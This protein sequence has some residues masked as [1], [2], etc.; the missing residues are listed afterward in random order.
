MRELLLS[1]LVTLCGD[2]HA[3]V[4]AVNDV[5]AGVQIAIARCDD[6]STR[7]IL[8]ATDPNPI[9]VECTD[10]GDLVAVRQ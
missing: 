1:A 6:C 7:A 5:L 9:Q 3:D 8:D 2:L 10:T 4:L